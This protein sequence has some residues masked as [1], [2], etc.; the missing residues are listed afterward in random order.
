MPIGKLVAQAGH[1]YTQSLKKAKLFYP[2]RYDY[3][4]NEKTGGS[5][6]AMSS[7]NV[8]HLIEAYN[9]A[10]ENDI[11]CCIFVDTNHIL[12]PHFD[13]SPIITA[14]GIG[15]CTKAEAKKLTKKFKCL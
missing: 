8:E 13:G 1:G 14:L 2:Q 6:V 9:L 4:L 11:P 12:L 3:Y 15:P 5:K 10:L 7:K